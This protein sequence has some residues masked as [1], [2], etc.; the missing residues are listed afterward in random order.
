MN[1]NLSLWQVE[2]QGS[3]FDL[4]HLKNYFTSAPMLVRADDRSPGFLYES[5]KF[6]TCTRSVEV[7]EVAAKELLILSGILKLIRDSTEPLRTGAVYRQNAAGG[8]DIFVHIHEELHARAEAG[9]V[10]VTITDMEGNVVSV[11]PPPPRT[12]ALSKLAFAD[13]AVA[14]V[15]RLIAVADSNSWVNLYRMHEVVEADVGGEHSLKKRAWGS[16]RD[17]KRFKHSANSVTVAGDRARHGT[18]TGQP[19]TQPM[20]IDEANAYVHCVIHVWLASKRA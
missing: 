15:M 19:P 14:K 8:R 10:G 1:T 9:I 16:S 17:L 6:L 7:L 5:E 20:S 18:E 2:V 3:Q 11:P 12:I 13:D 4:D